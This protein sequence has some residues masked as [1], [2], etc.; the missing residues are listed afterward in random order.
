MSSR[1]ASAG[2]GPAR[3][4][5]AVGSSGLPGRDQGVRGYV[6]VRLL[7]GDAQESPLTYKQTSIPFLAEVPLRRGARLPG[8]RDLAGRRTLGRDPSAAPVPSPLARL[9]RGESVAVRLD[10]ELDG[11]L[12]LAQ[13][14]GHP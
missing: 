8:P 14:W 3:A 7:S 12:R 6:P 4:S 10:T 11:S 9:S 2:P 5:A 13:P 1:S